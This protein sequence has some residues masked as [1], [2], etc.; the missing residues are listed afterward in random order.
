MISNKNITKIAI[1][2]ISIV[3]VICVVLIGFSE[4]L[5]TFNTQGINTEYKTKLFDTSNIMT[6][7]IVIDQN[8][9]DDLIANAT[10]ETY[11]QC[12]VVINNITFSGV[13][14]RAK[15]NTSLSSIASDPDSDR[16]S[17]KI[18]FEEY[19]D[20]QN[21]YGLDKL[22]LNNNYGDA[23]NMKEA[24]I[25]DMF[26]F[27]GADA[28]L[29]NY[30]KVSINGKYWGVYL[31]LEGIED[32]F[33]WRNYGAQSG[34]LYKPDGMN[35][36]GKDKA[37]QGGFEPPQ[38]PQGNMF[39]GNMP[40]IPQG[41]MPQMPQGD[42]PQMPQMEFGDKQGDFGGFGGFGGMG[43]MGGANLN[44]IDDNLDSYSTIW[45]GEI[46]KT[47]NADHERVVT[48]L[49]NISE[50]QN[51]EKYMDV[52]NLLRYMTVHNF[53]VNEDSLS[54]SMA[55]NYY[56]HESNGMLNILP[57]DYNLMF[58]GMR[59]SDATGIVNDPIDEPY[60]S[61][62]F[63]NSL[64]QNED[65]LQLYHQYYSELIENYFLGGEF[66]KT[67]TRIRNQIDELVATDPSA[68]YTYDEYTTAADTLYDAMLLRA[69][70]VKAQLEGKI[71]T[72]SSGQKQDS[73]SLIDAS[74]IDLSVTGGM[75]GGFGPGD[76]GDRDQMREGFEKNFER[77][78][79]QKAP[80]Q[81]TDA[82]SSRIQGMTQARPGQ[83]ENN[84]PQSSDGFKDFGQ[85][86]MNRTQTNT[87]NNKY[88]LLIASGVLLIAAF[89]FVI[90][91][92][93]KR[94]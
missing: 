94:Y 58:G 93:R 42:M 63:F 2:L 38:M 28:P 4:K 70:S 73:S 43:G 14:L 54:G 1:A 51:V 3:L 83:R 35:M 19:T 5:D 67:Y 84:N 87:Q 92:K 6:V 66:E 90:F 71:P 74:S 10:K 15:G 50:N 72:T 86:S 52:D 26:A 82:S 21:C 31:A 9:W 22:V 81:N 65:Y 20:G 46:T 41:E 36:G 76:R 24:I 33:L 12:D 69:Q 77:N 62:K 17:F 18:Q 8:K 40:Q 49:K 89:L 7:D 64:L 30:A 88:T 75:G 79:T 56:L 53:S 25:Y 91:Y 68:L 32:S 16:F 13:G 39:Q 80:Q 85:F 34:E 48:A 11:Y 59:S 57:W 60:S 27:V 44:Y 45:N 55:H 47:N 29:Y 61:T 37:D 78:N 23:T